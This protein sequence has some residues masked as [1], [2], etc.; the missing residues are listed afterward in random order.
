MSELVAAGVADLP[1]AGQHTW[2]LVLEW[3]PVLPLLATLVA[4]MA[5]RMRDQRSPLSGRLVP[6][7]LFWTS[8]I[9][10]CLAV[11]KPN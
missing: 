9:L 3:L 2:V 1:Q 8:L 11:P 4:V 6:Q 5:L 10:L 7:V